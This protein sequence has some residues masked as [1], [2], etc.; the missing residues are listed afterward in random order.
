MAVSD[1]IANKDLEITRVQLSNI[2][3]DTEAV[4]LVSPHLIKRYL[5][6]PLRLHA[7]AIVAAMAE[8]PER[9][10]L[11]DIR[12]V[13][14]LELIPVLADENELRAA[15]HQYT[16]FYFDPLMQR[17]LGDLDD[18]NLV[19]EEGDPG[20]IN[21]DNE[22][23]IV[24]LVNS[25]LGQ[26]VD[27]KCSDIHIEPQKQQTRVRFRIDG[28]LH[29]II[30]LPKHYEAIVVS[31]IKVMAGMDIAEKRVPQEGRFKMV[32]AGREVDFRASSL[33]VAYGEKLVL[34]IL[35][36]EQVI[37]RIEH[38][39][40][41]SDNKK[42]IESISNELYGMV[43]IVG[44]TGSG[45]T[46]TLYSILNEINSADKNIIT[47]E[48]PVEYSLPGIN[49]VQVNAKTG[50]SFAR[51]LRSALRQDPDVIMLGEIRDGE[52]AKLA[53][54]AALTGHLM[55]A[56]LHANS[57]AG[58]V[59]RLLDLDVENFLI[60]S[61]LSGVVAQR[62]VRRLCPWC[63]QR[64]ILER[65]TAETILKPALSGQVFYRAQG[66]NVCRQ[67]GYSGRIAL[68]EIVNVDSEFKKAIIKGRV[69]EEELNNIAINRGFK[70][71]LED[72][73]EK[74][75]AGLTSLEEVIKAVYTQGER[76][77]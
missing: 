25:I 55:L 59:A 8:P 49:Q 27:G 1:R 3:I 13:T 77:G 74:A 51:G 17:L 64:Y 60:A 69:G 48:E 68:H 70:T 5:L 24:K 22:A 61:A 58:A 41:S 39:G 20:F 18:S 21:L 46:T 52:T 2:A 30:S 71:L 42:K 34:R 76:D 43:L 54:Q 44:P 16:T 37:N 36:Q 12:L 35:N 56:T 23:P 33:P 32:L 10:V 73:I 15:I 47:L 28:A 11:D 62:L 57:A 29:E 40:L 7:G 14:G 4:K 66:C 6:L 65:D 72:G 53:V 26:A 31:R 67:M 63:R 19:A 38:L 45:K 50:L 9:Q 75:G